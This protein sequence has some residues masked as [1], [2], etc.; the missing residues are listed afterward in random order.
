M[1]S[2]LIILLWILPV[3]VLYLGIRCSSK[4][5]KLIYYLYNFT[6]LSCLLGLLVYSIQFEQALDLFLKFVKDPLFWIET[7]SK[8][9]LC[10]VVISDILFMIV[11]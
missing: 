2:L 6:Y 5:L 3:L 9:L 8:I 7:V 10:N 4:R 11:F 1:I